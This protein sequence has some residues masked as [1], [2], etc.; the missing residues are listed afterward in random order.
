MNVER[1]RSGGI[2]GV[3]LHTK[4]PVISL[5]ISELDAFGMQCFTSCSISLLSAILYCY[6]SIL[7]Q[8]YGRYLLY[9]VFRCKVH[10]SHFP[11]TYIRCSALLTIKL[12]HH[13]VSYTPLSSPHFL[14]MTE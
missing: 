2:P 4:K 14:I 6:M 8:S 9:E 3:Q 7:T 13:A 12:L 11:L 5:G 10:Y 1:K